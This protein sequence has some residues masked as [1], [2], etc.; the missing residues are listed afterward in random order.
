MK[1]SP[2]SISQPRDLLLRSLLVLVVVGLAYR[3]FYLQ[4][5][6]TPFLQDKAANRHVRVIDEHAHRGMISDRNG[7]PLAIS[8]A[9][10][11]L[12]ADPTQF[13]AVRHRWGELAQLLEMPAGELDQ[14]IGQ[15][16]GRRFVYIQR[17]L[18]PPLAARVKALGLPGLYL[19]REYRRYY[20]T[21]EV[22]GHLLGFTNID[23]QGQEGIEL[24]FDQ[25][26]RG[27]P[28]RIRIVQD[29]YRR[30]VQPV[31]ALE[32]AVPGSDMTVTLDKRLQY[33][34]Y[35]E[36]KAAVHRHRATSGSLVLIEI[37]SGDVLAMVNQPSF[38]PNEM[39]SRKP[40]QLRN[41]AVT[42]VFEPGST[43]KPFII[44]AALQAGI[45]RP[46]SQIDTTPGEF[47][48]G[49]HRIRD[50]R[51]LGVITLEQVLQKSSNVGAARIALGMDPVE[52]EEMLRD[53]G[54]G[55][56]TES[57]LLG[58]SDGI[59]VPAYNWR[60]IDHATLAYGYGLS[61]TPLQLARAYA[62][63]GN[64]GRSVSVQVV[65]RE[66]P[67]AQEQLLRPEVADSVV[68]MLESVVTREGTG[69]RAAVENYRIAGKTGTAHMFH[70]GGYD[71][72]RY[73]TTFAGLA[74]A[75]AP[76]L[77]LV[78]TIHDPKGE[79]Y[80]A[81]D[82]A[83]PVFSRVMGRALRLLKIPPDGNLVPTQLTEPT[84]V[85]T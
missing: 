64:H 11:S 17:R 66:T 21:G 15:R 10:D 54:F 81:G 3:A 52:L 76:R 1:W 50:H 26:L 38:N 44:A 65:P 78:V 67:A 5:L 33:L 55:R 83:A 13:V 19:Q 16:L 2:I 39:A 23:D 7:E 79:A 53:M 48:V 71:K 73:V 80:Y 82:V 40:A 75:S 47:R 46:G 14:L 45:Y 32:L 20:P 85:A 28:G 42:D 59:L 22:S 43:I 69:Y 12:W 74:P 4:V 36:L 9:V 61:V 57:Q 51:S 58:E 34:A 25:S 24:Q 49:G 30:W 37:S 31:E 6:Q 62:V 18:T 29:L 27:K 84:G 68:K 56:S 60:K 8:T 63:L 35:R 41:R 77:A 70:N 72:E